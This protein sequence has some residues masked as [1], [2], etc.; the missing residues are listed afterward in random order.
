[1][2]IPTIKDRVSVDL[3]ALD[4]QISEYSFAFQNHPN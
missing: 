3:W 1:M 2:V 4:S